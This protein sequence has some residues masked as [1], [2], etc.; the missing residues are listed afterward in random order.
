MNRYHSPLAKEVRI[1]L[2][3]ARNGI[4]RIATSFPGVGQ[5][6]LE[7]TDGRWLCVRADQV[8]LEARFEVFPI[9]ASIE[10]SKPDTKVEAEYLLAPPVG[11]TE[12]ETEDWLDP[13][14][15]CGETLGCNPVAQF[16]DLPGRATATASAVCRY[17]S[18]VR[19]DGSNGRSV[20]IATLAFPYSIY[21]SVFPE[22]ASPAD[23]P[24]VPPSARETGV[25]DVP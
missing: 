1:A 12:L 15:A 22:G 19:F 3:E 21:C 5:V 9:G 2:L 20:V 16:Q 11:V 10:S 25:R 18:G 24:H 6:Y 23:S 7:L 17:V 13:V 8:D 14:V 4:R